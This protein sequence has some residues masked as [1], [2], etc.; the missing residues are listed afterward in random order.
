MNRVADSFVGNQI[1]LKLDETQK[2]YEF[3]PY[4]IDVDDGLLLLNGEVV[5]LPPKTF[6]L[7][8]VF[9]ESGGRVITKT[10][11][12][13]RVWPDSFVE[14]ANLSHHV[15]TLRKTLGEDKNGAKF[16]ET[17]PRRG[18]RFVPGVAEV[19]DEPDEVIVAEHTRSHI[20]IE[21]DQ[22]PDSSSDYGE[23][24]PIR[25][26]A[27]AAANKRHTRLAVACLAVVMALAVAGY[28]WKTRRPTQPT[29]PGFKSI[30]VLPFK[31]LVAA[32]RNEALELG[33]ADTLIAKL[34]G[35]RQLIVR[36]VSA[37]RTYAALDQ[38]PIAAGRGLEVDYVVEGHLLMDGDKVRATIRLL[39]VG[40][41]VAIW[42]DQCDQQCSSIFALQDA[43]A[44]Q[45]V[46][47]LG[48][49]LSGGERQQLAKHYTEN[50]DA[51]RLYVQGRFFWNKRSED[52]FK[53]GIE[54][55]TQALQIDPTYAL[56]HSGLADCYAL[57][58]NSSR[59]APNEGFPKAK[60]ATIQALQIDDSLAEAHTSLAFI[61]YQ[62]DHNF[63]LAEQ[64]FKRALEL[65]PAY[66]TAH[67]WYADFLE[68]MGRDDEALRE[69]QLAQ[70]NDPLSLV[71]NAELADYYR[72]A[73]QVD[74]ALAQIHKTLEMDP[75]FVRTHQTLGNVYLETRAYEKAIAEF[76]LAR[77][78]NENPRSIAVLGHAYAV[79][80]NKGEAHKIIEE[81]ESLSTK[82]YV[83]G[84]YIAS[85]YAGLGENDRAFYWVDKAYENHED[86]TFLTR[87]ED[88]KP[89]R[90]DPRFAERLRRF[91]ISP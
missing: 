54:Y 77:Q 43:V 72:R 40:D 41:G 44:Q 9:A 16:I 86:A 15:F 49:E 32:Q 88:F 65:N 39:R 68:W 51:Y 75:N 46:G 2:H 3:G 42:T 58:A 64:E 57:L 79:A 1:D 35:I 78:L 82:Q 62:F 53:K 55:F 50:T 26:L 10:E 28:F 33:M 27:L 38:D 69:A 76:K 87:D 12:M 80:G 34:S 31:P 71:I 47:K 45:V 84:R 20:I 5:A 56:A 90:S 63:D 85:I 14:E 59:L 67:Q 91:G 30:A 66:A 81:L 22:A 17:I 73:G 4:R 60:A 7:L 74:T 61:Y 29:A 25:N 23:S 48:H 8:V 70:Q 89:L 19:R 24:T 18:Y 11:L 37:I 52:G 21:R 83:G 13:S 36:P 6:D